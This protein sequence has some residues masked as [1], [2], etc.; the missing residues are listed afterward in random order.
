MSKILSMTSYALCSQKGSD[1]TLSWEIKSVNARFLDIQIKLPFKDLGL[2][3]QLKKIIQAKTQR[4]KIEAN[5]K[6]VSNS[7]RIKDDAKELTKLNRLLEEIRKRIPETRAITFGEIS[8]WLRDDHPHKEN[9]IPVEQKPIISL[10]SQTLEIF[11][12]RRA[13]EGMALGTAIA[14][15][16]S[17]IEDLLS[18]QRDDL[19]RINEKQRRE[20]RRRTKLFGSK[21]GEDRILQELAILAQKSDIHE[22]LDRLQAHTKDCKKLLSSKGPHG[23]RIDFIAQELNREA[24]TMGSKSTDIQSSRRALDLKILIEQIREQTQNIE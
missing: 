18:A 12:S 9:S 14:R 23:K 7:S 17:S 5:L 10:F 24:N 1:Y 13:S 6:I 20:L 21:I 8:E 16:L 2:E 11:I 4:G 3:Q 19:S 15:R 22:E